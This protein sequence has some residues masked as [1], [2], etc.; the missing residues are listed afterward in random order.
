MSLTSFP[1]SGDLPSVSKKPA[2]A[3]SGSAKSIRS[4]MPSC[5]DAGPAF[6][7][8]PTSGGLTAP[9]MPDGLTLSAEA[10]PANRSAWQDRGVARLMKDISGRR[11]LDS[12]VKSGRDGSLPRMLLDTLTSVSTRL[13]HRWSLKASP[14]GRSIFALLPLTRTIEGKGY[15]LLPTPT[16]SDCKGA[17]ENCRRIKERDLSYLRFY[18]HFHARPDYPVSY[19]HPA[20]VERM[21]GYPIGHTDLGLSETRSFRKSPRSSAKP[22]CAL[23][24]PQ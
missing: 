2:C 18:L 15:G 3:Q 19:P 9:P 14:S 1:G 17:T 22:S 20:F 24:P 16:A 13:P 8:T 12:Y 5:N 23:R 21:M 10:I 4:A 6:P 11:C 7:S